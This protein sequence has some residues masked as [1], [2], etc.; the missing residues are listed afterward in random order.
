MRIIIKEDGKIRLKEVLEVVI[1]KT[2][3]LVAREP[4]IGMKTREFL[5]GDKA[6]ELFYQIFT[7]GYADLSGFESH[8]VRYDDV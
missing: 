7:D 3:N 8:L 6:E 2:G 5:T 1:G 4:G